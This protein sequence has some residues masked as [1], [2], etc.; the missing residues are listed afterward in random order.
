M[1]ATWNIIKY[2]MLTLLVVVEFFVI[3]SF[4]STPVE[5]SFMFWIVT[6]AGFE[7]FDQLN[8]EVEGE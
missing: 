8:K 2:P 3:A 1:T 4:S 5:H 6:V 7:M